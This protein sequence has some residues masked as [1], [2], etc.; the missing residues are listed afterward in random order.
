[1]C[2]CNTKIKSN[3]R[4]HMEITEIEKQADVDAVKNLISNSFQDIWSDLDETKI[5]NH[6]TSDFML[7]ENGAVWNNNS[8]VNYMKERQVDK[9][10][11]KRINKF[12]YIQTK[13]NKNSIWIAYNNY[14]NWVKGNDT[15]REA[16]WLESAVAIKENNTWKLEQLH[17]TR[18][19]K[20]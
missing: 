1:M 7:L 10:E 5:L 3:T 12:E 14:A 16:H 9:N 15:L 2:S 19:L 8:I 20:K 18:V 13:H 6:Y 11:V 4:D 17:S